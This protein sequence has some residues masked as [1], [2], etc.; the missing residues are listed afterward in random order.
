M[1][2]HHNLYC[3]SI[4]EVTE[5]PYKQ[6]SDMGPGPDVIT[7]HKGRLNPYRNQ[8]VHVLCTKTDLLSTNPLTR[9]F[10]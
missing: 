7:G 1:P 3:E 8:C 4:L 5:R 10:P 9:G 2:L 6:D